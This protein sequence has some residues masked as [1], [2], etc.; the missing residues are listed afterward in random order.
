M[1]M[2]PLSHKRELKLCGLRCQKQLEYVISID[3]FT[4]ATSCSMGFPDGSV[5]KHPSANAEDTGDMGLIP[6]F[7]KSP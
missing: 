3:S 4:D 2:I 7:G 5:V 6:G 1:P